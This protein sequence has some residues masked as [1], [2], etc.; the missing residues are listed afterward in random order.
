MKLART[1]PLS[2]LAFLAMAAPAAAAP[3]VTIGRGIQPSV[4]VDGAG[5]GHIVRYDTQGSPDRMI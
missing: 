4:A 5:T 2:L 3:S 1:L